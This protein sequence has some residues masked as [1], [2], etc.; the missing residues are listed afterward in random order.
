MVGGQTCKV[1][2]VQCVN[3]NLCSGG[4]G[5]MRVVAA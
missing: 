4:I 2:Y 3:S 1:N 5:P